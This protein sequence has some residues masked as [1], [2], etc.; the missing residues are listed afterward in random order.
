M[1]ATMAA[2]SRRRTC[3]GVIVVSRLAVAAALLVFAGPAPTAGSASNGGFV[4][5]FDDDLPKQAGAAAVAA[6]SDA[7]AGALRFTLQWSSGETALTAADK[8]GLSAAVSAAA[9][10]RVVLSVYGAAGSEAPVDAAG[11][12]NY[13][14]YVANALTLNPPIRDVVIWNEPNKR[15]FWN[16]AGS[17]QANAP[18]QYEALLASCYDSLHSA[19]ASVNV[20]GLAVS[21]TGND[22]ASSTSPGAFIRDIGEA[23]RASGRTMPVLDTV[24]FHPYPL[25]A[26]ERPWLQHIGQKT[27]AEGDW[28]KLMY[29]LWLAFHGSGQPLPGNVGITIW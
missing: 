27:I 4:V 10:F 17:G 2:A 22:D 16:A 9:G 12:S 14:A 6:A 3:G 7:G 13:C 21:S 23:Y 28:N 19:F 5:G 25:N 11:R 26:P 1:V 18:A 24:G 8:A 15:L 20:I 29:N